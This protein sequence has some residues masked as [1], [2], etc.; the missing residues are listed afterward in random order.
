MKRRMA[1]EIAG[2]RWKRPRGG[3]VRGASTLFTALVLV[4]TGVHAARAA[5]PLALLFNPASGAPGA[6]VTITGTGFDDASVANGVLFHEV[7]A[8]S[9]TVDSD[10][11][12]TAVVPAGATTGP[13]TVTDSEGSSSSVIDF[14]VSS[15]PTPTIAAFV[16]LSGPTGTSVTID[17]TGFTSASSVEFDGETAG[18]TVDSD[19]Q[20]TTTV[21][22]G[23]T[24][25]PISVTTPN[26]TGAS[27]VDF[28]V[29]DAP[30]RH[31]RS[32]TLALTNRLVATGRVRADD[33][34]SR[35]ESRAHVVIQRRGKRH[36]AVVG[37]DKAGNA[38]RFRRHLRDRRG[39]YRAVAPRHV[40]G[41]NHV[42]GRGVS[43]VRNVA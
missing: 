20:I 33:G 11:Q 15:P 27:L 39:R 43:P 37:H 36:W 35:C 5:P 21:P 30:E 32:V 6:S 13:I 25:G 10:V 29:T 40:V 8:A 2:A 4:V 1:S 3:R 41:A 28:T 16:P 18:F 22:L 12:I 31:N 26:G 38:G 34:F 24:T 23:G 14:T 7:A 42:C 17:G 19:I 9:F